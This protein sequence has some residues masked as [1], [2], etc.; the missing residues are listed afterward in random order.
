LVELSKVGKGSS[1]PQCDRQSGAVFVL[2]VVFLAI[3]IVFLGVK[4]VPQGY[5]WTVE[6]FGR[7]TRMLRPGLNLVVPFIDNWRWTGCPR[8]SLGFDRPPACVRDALDPNLSAAEACRRH[9]LF[10][11][12]EN[13]NPDN[14]LAAK[15]R[16]NRITEYRPRT[17]RSVPKYPRASLRRQRTKLGNV[18]SACSSLG[19]G[20]DTQQLGDDA[21]TKEW[22]A[23]RIDIIRTATRPPHSRW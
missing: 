12:L 22:S 3:L 23:F 21:E 4:T 19:I 1:G 16:Q 8:S 6:R 2:I 10:I 17:Q 11:G 7:Y 18:P 5:N 14:L 15:K 9:T 13:I 20:I